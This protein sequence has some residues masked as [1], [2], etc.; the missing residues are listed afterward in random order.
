MCYHKKYLGCG[1]EVKIVMKKLKKNINSLVQL[2]FDNRKRYY[3]EDADLNYDFCYERHPR[4]PLKEVKED[5][6][7]EN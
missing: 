2:F 5:E 3:I 4:C 7:T 6:K 1:V